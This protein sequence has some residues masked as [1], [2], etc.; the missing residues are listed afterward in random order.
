MT[1]TDTAV[2]KAALIGW[3]ATA[4]ARIATANPKPAPTT[5]IANRPA[6]MTRSREAG[7][8]RRTV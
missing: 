8:A 3:R 2:P 6:L 1:V 5:P 4:S 7:P